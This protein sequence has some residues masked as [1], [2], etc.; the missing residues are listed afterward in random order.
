MALGTLALW[1]QSF[2]FLYTVLFLMSTQ[3]SFFGPSKYSLL[4]EMLPESRLSW[5]NGL[6]DQTHQ[7]MSSHQPTV[8]RSGTALRGA[9]EV[10]WLRV[11]VW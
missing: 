7:P 2:P 5:G 11:C 9:R 3:S 10:D 4:P 1:L 6:I 8:R